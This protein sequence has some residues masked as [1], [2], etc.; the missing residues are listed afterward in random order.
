MQATITALNRIQIWWHPD[1]G[2]LAPE[3]RKSTS[4]V[5]ASHL[6][7]FFNGSPSQ[8]RQ[9]YTNTCEHILP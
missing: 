5:Q 4:T 6:W 9:P 1:N 7:Y 2:L 3:L 8:L